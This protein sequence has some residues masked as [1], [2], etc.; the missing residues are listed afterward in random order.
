MEVCK[1]QCLSILS[2]IAYIGVIAFFSSSP[3]P[4]KTRWGYKYYKVSKLIWSVITPWHVRCT[5]SA[6][7]ETIQSIIYHINSLELISQYGRSR[8]NDIFIFRKLLINQSDYP[9]TLK[10]YFFL[11]VCGYTCIHLPV[12]FAF[13]LIFLRQGLSVDP[14]FT[15]CAI[16]ASH[17]ALRIPCLCLL[18]FRA[19]RWLSH[20][21]TS[22]HVCLRSQLQSSHLWDKHFI[23]WAISS[24]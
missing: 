14:E 13:H 19:Y 12:S 23:Y 3:C 2:F 9:R 7:N 24:G 15:D 6:L 1:S 21:S 4:L 16:L 5:Q 10:F 18:S 8:S 17:L 20:S 11:I 22:L